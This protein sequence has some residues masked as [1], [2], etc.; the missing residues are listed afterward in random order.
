MVDIIYLEGL[1]RKKNLVKKKTYVKLFVNEA[2][3]VVT[4][5]FNCFT[6]NID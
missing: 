5:C 6:K 2:T 3:V 4:E 1:I